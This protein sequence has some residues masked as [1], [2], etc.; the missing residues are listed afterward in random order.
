MRLELASA[1]RG[2]IYEMTNG[3]YYKFDR[4]SK[5]AN[6]GAGETFWGTRVSKT[7]HKPT[8]CVGEFSW[9]PLRLVCGI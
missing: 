1:K 4:A 9:K 2:E 7:S 8:D 6:V 5:V 3:I